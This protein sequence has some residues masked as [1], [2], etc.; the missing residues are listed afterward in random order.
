MTATMTG[1]GTLIG[2]LSVREIVTAIKEANVTAEE[3]AAVADAVR[4]ASDD[5]SPRALAETVPFAAKLIT[6]ASRA[7]KHWRGLL[8]LA[9]TLVPPYI[10]HTDAQQAHRDA[11][12]A[13]QDA[14]RAH[15]DA[16]R[17]R[18]ADEQAKTTGRLSDGDIRAIADQM[19]ERLAEAHRERDQ[20]R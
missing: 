20:D 6:V 2:E 3:L 8:V 12:Q 4:E 9:V 5:V 13:R 16:E 18:R 17:A 19:L 1:R 10:A 7:G 15:E 11:V 14:Q